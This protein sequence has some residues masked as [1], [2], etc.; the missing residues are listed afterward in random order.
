[1]ESMSTRN[2][3]RRVIFYQEKKEYNF[4]TILIFSLFVGCMRSLEEIMLAH[5]HYSQDDVLN[6]CIFYFLMIWSY[7]LAVSILSKENWQK[8]INAVLIGVF[9]GVFPPVIDVFVYGI[10]KFDYRYIIDVPTFSQLIMFDR[11]H[12]FPVGEGIILWSTTIFAGYYVYIKSSSFTRAVIG[13]MAAYLINMNSGMIIP[14]ISDRIY[15]FFSVSQMTCVSIIQL[16]ISIVFYLI[17]NRQ[18]AA[19]LATRS[20]HCMPFVILTLIGAQ[21]TGNLRYSAFLMALI[22]FFAGITALVQNDFFDRKEDTLAGIQT[23][24]GH[25]DVLFFNCSFAALLVVLF[26]VRGMSSYLPLV[27]LFICSIIYNHDFYRTKRFFP[28]NYK[29]EGMWGLGSFLAGIFLTR[30]PTFAPEIILY[31]FL[32]FGGWS[33]VSTFKDYKDI[34]ADIAVG[35]QTGYIMLMKFGLDL[36]QAHRIICGT[37]S[38]CLLVPVAWLF[39]LKVPVLVALS[40]PLVTMPPFFFAFNKPQGKEA[41]RNFILAVSFY[42]LVLLGILIKYYNPS[43]SAIPY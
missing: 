20:L 2:W 41:V 22:V 14:A 21:L 36:E 11:D 35:N 26:A 6:T 33:L 19:R 18:V 10:G 8:V 32:V 16:A 17:L 43:M 24:I 37:I 28:G 4:Y 12:G 13:G 27:L 3:I 42:L 40:F 34:D 38:M 1:M 5:K 39:Y 23:G 25:H 29:I 9:L 31:S 7:T 30:R 15:P